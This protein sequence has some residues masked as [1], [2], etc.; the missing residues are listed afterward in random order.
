MLSIEATFRTESRQVVASLM[1]RGATIEQ[2]E[3]A[4]QEAFVVAIETWSRDGTP[5]RPGAWITTTAK[6]RLIDRLRREARRSDKEL[7]SNLAGSLDQTDDVDDDRLGLIFTCCHPA[8]NLDARVGLTLR[9]VCGL[10][11]SEVAR[12]FVVAEPTMAQ[13]LVRAQHKIAVTNIAFAVPTGDDLG[14][15]VSAVLAVVYTVFTAG[16]NA[17]TAGDATKVTL[18]DEAIRLARLLQLLLPNDTE[19]LALLALLLLHDARR[20]AR[21]D[22]DSLVLFADQDRAR[23]N[24]AELREGGALI[25][26][27][28]RMGP[29]GQY[30]L[31]AAIAA[32]HTLPASAAE[33]DWRRIAS[34]HRLLV[35]HTRGSPVARLNHAIAVSFADGPAAGLALIDTITELASHS[36]F[37]AARADL[38]ARLDRHGE[39]AD[40]YRR[41][42]ETTED[43]R[44]RRSLQTALDK[45]S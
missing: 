45:L 32:E 24:A 25:D 41:A 37:H 31:Q 30:W 29:V 17:V 40:A 33:R 9:A 13:R 39:A 6:R 15:R 28:A 35:E 2:A 3:D 22:D 23:W 10:S 7:M 27:A 11:T 12:L 16:Y 20:D 14:P 1:R 38:L 18:C 4:L 44:R 21:V 26:R 43:E 8:L 42:I 5:V 36:D 34:L 19:V